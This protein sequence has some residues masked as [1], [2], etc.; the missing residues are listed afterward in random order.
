MFIMAYNE[1]TID[2]FTFRNGN[3]PPD[4]DSGGGLIGHL[5]APVI[6]NCTFTGNTAHN[7]GGLWYGGVSA[8]VIEDCI[9]IDNHADNGGGVCLVNSSTAARLVR[10][11]AL[12]NTATNRGGGIFVYHYT[13]QLEGCTLAHNEAGT[14]GGGLCLQEAYPSTATGCTIVE[15]AAPEG[16]G[17]H[18]KYGSDLLV[19]RSV[20]AWAHEGGALGMGEEC[21]LEVG[22]CLLY[23]NA[24]GDSLP[25]GAVDAGHNLELD[26]QFCGV[27]GSRNWT[28]QADS[29][30]LPF[31]HP[32]GLLCQRIGAWPAGCGTVGTERSSWGSIRKI[33]R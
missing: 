27:K 17:L 28:V 18:C 32:E 13:A 15:N 5:S 23:G 22:C 29:P 26:P 4:Y 7:G 10:C 16:G 1:L 20:F 9:F 31:N 14:S 6:R 11:L 21:L 30:C 19:T 3:A 24:G 33:A 2:G 8:P 12:G 25:A